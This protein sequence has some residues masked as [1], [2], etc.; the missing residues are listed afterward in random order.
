MCSVSGAESVV[1]ENFCKG[2]KFFCKFG[3]VFG[4]F[5]IITN[6]FEK[7]DFAFFDGCGNIFCV[8]ADNVFAHADFAFKKFGKSFCNGSKRKFR[9]PFAFRSSEMGAE[10]YLCAVFLEVFDGGK[11]GNDSFVVGDNAFFKRYV[12]IAADKNFFA[13]YVDVFDGHFVCGVH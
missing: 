7:S 6:V 3:N 11:G 10:N 13:G 1:Y 9:K 5:F 2:S 4:F 12:E 8:F